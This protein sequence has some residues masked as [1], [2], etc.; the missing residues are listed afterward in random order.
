MYYPQPP[1]ICSF[2]NASY[3][4]KVYT[5]WSGDEVYEGNDTSIETTQKVV[6]T[7]FPL[8]FQAN[9]LY[10]AVITYRTQFTTIS[11]NVSFSKW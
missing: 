2:Q 8:V 9:S 3:I 4:V 10:H 6:E 11:T 7:E 5:S 1:A